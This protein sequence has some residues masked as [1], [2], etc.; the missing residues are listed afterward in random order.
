MKRL[1]AVLL[2]LHLAAPLAAQ[3]F[4]PPDEDTEPTSVQ[5]GITGFGARA[6]V[7]FTGANQLISSIS[8]DIADLYTSRFRLRPS[9]E[10]GIGGGI[11]T[12]LVN[13]DVIWRFVS[14][15]ET[16]VPYIGAGFGVFAANPG[17]GPAPGCPK[18]WP[19]FEL[20]FE[21][22]FRPGINWLIEYRAEDLVRRHRFFVGLTT[23]RGD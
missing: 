3:D 6:G 14:D 17:C 10:I 1:F 22:R 7:D 16:A 2:A 18:F 11:N 15:A 8:L 9:G 5:F 19:Q 13:L 12:Y 21:L 4:R 23:R 20:G